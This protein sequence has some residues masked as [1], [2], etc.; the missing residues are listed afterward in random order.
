M[1]KVTD[2]TA[3]EVWMEVIAWLT[4][5]ADLGSS[6]IGRRPQH[7][8]LGL[9]AELL[10]EKAVRLLQ[11]ADRAVGLEIRWPPP[12]S[13]TPTPQTPPLPGTLTFPAAASRGAIPGRAAGSGPVGVGHFRPCH[14][15]ADVKAVKSNGVSVRP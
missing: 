6:Q 8:C 10:A 4:E 1:T 13:R 3:V 7:Y 2:R 9:G 12:Q 11:D 5:A 15:T 14:A